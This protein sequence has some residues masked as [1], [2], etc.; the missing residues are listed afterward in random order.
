M[1][2]SLAGFGKIGGENFTQTK[3]RATSAGMMSNAAGRV[4]AKIAAKSFQRIE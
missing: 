1:F 2:L 4:A 3:G